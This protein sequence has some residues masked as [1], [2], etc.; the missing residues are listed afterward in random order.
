MADRGLAI[1][2]LDG[3]L[4]DTRADLASA[5]NRTRLALGLPAVPL[6]RVVDSVGNGLSKLLERIIPERD[7]V[8]AAEKRALW[9]RE[10]AAHWLDETALYPGIA[11]ALRD[12][13]RRGWRLA[14]LSNKPDEATQ[15]VVAG[16]GIAGW[17]GVV[18]GG[19]PG[20]PLKPDP[21]SVEA[22]V[23]ASGYDGP[24]SR[25]WVVGDNYTD[26]AAARNAGVKSCFCR[27]GFGRAGDEIPSATAGSAW[28]LPEIL[29][30]NPRQPSL[31]TRN[32]M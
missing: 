23:R 6:A 13:C 1:F 32:L 2:D 17:F 10:Y 12:L 11:E 15:A 25:I 5:V 29:D 21:A 4:A 20:I 8:P 9:M 14:V 3:T 27:F 18:Q 28:E 16:L 26:L 19:T 7:D 24:R 30:C 22:V 31:P